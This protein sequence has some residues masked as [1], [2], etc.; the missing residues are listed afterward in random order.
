MFFVGFIS[1]DE[2]LCHALA[3]QLS[4]DDQWQHTVF[5]SLEDALAAWSDALPPLIFWDAETAPAKD[6]MLDF[7]AMRLEDKTPNPVLLVLGDAPQ[8]IQKEGVTETLS[9][10]LRLGYLLT[11]LSFYR[12]ILQ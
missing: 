9:R 8:V 10:P 5:S 7:F 2:D 4:Q 11:R 6:D 12:R 1:A 3:E